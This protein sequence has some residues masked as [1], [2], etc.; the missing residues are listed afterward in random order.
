MWN[1]APVR[2]KSDETNIAV[3]KSLCELTNHLS[4]VNCV[5]WS[6]DGKW[7]A[8]GG[9]D[10]IIM[11]WQ[12]KHQGL[13]SSGFGGGTTHEQWK[14]VHMLRGHGSNILD[15]SWSPD[16]KYLASCS[17][18]NTIMIW[19]AKDLPQK[20]STISGHNGLV[21]GL[22]WDPVGKFLASQSDDRSVRIWRTNDWKEVKMITEPFKKCGGTTHVLRL[23]WSPDGKYI[24]SAHALNND[25][26]TAQIIERGGS[27]KAGMDFVGHRKA[28]EVVLFNPHLFI[29]SDAK[30]NHGCVALGGRDR[31]LSVWL[32]NLKRPLL[33]MHDLFDDSIL[34][35][36]WSHGGYELLVC[37]TDGTI[38]YLSFSS[39]ELGLRIS[40]QALDDLFMQTYGTK[41]AETTFND[42]NMVLIENP[43]ILKLHNS[44]P[45]KT[46]SGSASNLVSN[47][48]L[49]QSIGMTSTSA[50][51]ASV[52]KQVETRTKEG[53]RR[54]TPITLTTEPSSMS[55]APLPFTSFSPKQN[56]GTVLKT[57][58][59]KDPLKKEA[60]ANG[61]EHSTPK[62]CV[63][64]SED[65]TPPKPISF[66]AL[67]PKK[68]VDPCVSP[69]VSASNKGENTV[70][71]AGQKRK[72]E[73]A[74]I[75]PKA[76]KLKRR[77]AQLTI[78]LPSVHSPKPSTPQKQTNLQSIMKQASLVHLPVP[79]LESTISIMLLDSSGKANDD[80]PVIEIENNKETMHHSISYIEGSNRIWKMLFGSP[81]LVAAASQ[82]ITCIACQDK[83]LSL[84]STQ[85][86]RL[87]V[88][89]IFLHEI[90]YDLKAEG[91]F[92]MAVFCSGQ[93][94]MWDTRNMKTIT[95]DVSF[96]HLLLN[97]KQGPDKCLLTNE[98]IPVLKIGLNSFMLNLNLNC[99]ME[100]ANAEEVSEIR[101]MDFNF[102]SPSLSSDE[103][104][105]LDSLQKSSHVTTTR[106]DS[107]GLMLQQVRGTGSQSST[108]GYL[109]SQ[110]SR[111]LFLR[112]PLEYRHWCK[113]YV[114]FL[115]KE[116]LEGKLREFCR[117]FSSPV[118]R[119]EMVL[120]F[121]KL[122]LL[123]ELL[124][125]VARNTKLQRLYLEIKATVENYC[126]TEN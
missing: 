117:G 69:I 45:E 99:W 113:M 87:L 13:V 37:S 48:S 61:S 1:M 75:L 3:P 55:G 15:L 42:S 74:V 62:S 39:K 20:V 96:G 100:L 9:D 98:G 35:L 89:K 6:Q 23:S 102:V 10:A 57:T 76:K 118:G 66:E 64:Y 44:T 40:K 38:A 114:Q 93:L 58:P 126:R 29:K 108:L 120:G 2:T 11:I 83:S 24:V 43:E 109:E 104:T 28:V 110:I 78:G 21:K 88:G 105:P 82:Y 91:H 54:I 46:S 33:V 90:C 86:G 71:K 125:L 52:T 59:E 30:D 18:D 79:K 122:D 26:P 16:R 41:R 56:K 22:T 111:S 50:Q 67:S 36:S 80:S 103:S 4:C 116:N 72:V 53:K 27:W 124:A 101:G 73:E 32:T 107:V 81:C 68:I 31:S 17:V 7:L 19:N 77:G 65:K 49:N 85:T 84:Y 5:R 63:E 112:S 97:P 14:C 123:Q 94:S 92:L 47:N 8:S 121:A 25:G 60:A 12:I 34:D 70:S 106:S 119:D 115:A 95:Q 51:V